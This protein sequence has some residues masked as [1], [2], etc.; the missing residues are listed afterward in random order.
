MPG[1]ENVRNVEGVDFYPLYAW[2]AA[3][4]TP[5][6]CGE[7]R[8]YHFGAAIMNNIC[9][10]ATYVLTA[11][12]DPEICEAAASYDFGVLS[13]LIIMVVLALVTI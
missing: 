12:D 4:D 6:E 9:L 13:F 1:V 10:D 3:D 5:W 8:T 11:E 7:T 2:T